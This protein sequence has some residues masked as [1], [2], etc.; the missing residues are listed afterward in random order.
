V[1]IPGMRARAR[2]FGGRLDI[3]SRSRGTIVHAVMSIPR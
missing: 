1:G 3:R 2:Q